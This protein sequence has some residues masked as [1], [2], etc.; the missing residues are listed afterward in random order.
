MS[1]FSCIRIIACWCLLF[2]AAGA[3]ASNTILYDNT[4]GPAYGDSLRQ[5]LPDREL[6][7]QG[8]DG[9]LTLQM[10]DVAAIEAYDY[11]AEAY[12]HLRDTFYWYPQYTATVVIAL[13]RDVTA[14][15]VSGWKELA[16][17]TM[18]VCLV[19]DSPEY[20]TAIIAAGYG[21]SHR[22]STREGS[23]YFSRLWDADRLYIEPR[24]DRIQYFV[25]QVPVACEA[26][27]L[28]DYQAAQLNRLGRHL[29]IVVPVDGTLSFT[30]GL[31]SRQPL[32]I[33]QAALTSELRRHG[34]R[35]VGERRQ[36]QPADAAYVTA[37]PVQDNRALSQEMALASSYFLR[38]ILDVDYFLSNFRSQHVV[39]CLV[40]LF[41]VIF[42]MAL[43]RRRIVQLGVRQA[44]F[45]CSLSS[46][47]DFQIASD[48]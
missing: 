28:L 25:D 6:D 14:A 26:Y 33:D 32:A 8:S 3:A 39:H 24:R 37:A 31:L 45:C 48:R 20:M 5:A 11:Q 34:Y 7:V 2:V 42:S 21:M 1:L 23:K 43:V 27:V 10:S 16:D 9:I 15:S 47:A 46:P 18:N 36:V 17:S 19:M 41:L 30:K 44:L 38:E 13:D 22:V 4:Y 40:L 35:P 12:R 29:D